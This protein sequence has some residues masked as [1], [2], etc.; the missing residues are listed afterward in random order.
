MSH[1]HHRRYE[2]EKNEPKSP[3]S[4]SKAL[5]PALDKNDRLILTIARQLLSPPVQKIIDILIGISDGND[6]KDVPF[7]IPGLIAQLNNQ[8]ENNPLPELIST[9]MNSLS[10][11]N[12]GSLNPMLINSLLTMLNGKKES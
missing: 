8:G 5:F 11:E 12:K 1:H 7:D 9:L 10:G 6:L 2:L 3:E 4:I